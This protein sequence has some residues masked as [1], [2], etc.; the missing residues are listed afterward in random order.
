MRHEE[1]LLS[2]DESR[3]LVRAV[4]AYLDRTG[5]NYNRLV[6]A[7]AVN[8]SIRSDVTT[9]DKRLTIHTADK[10]RSAMKQN[11]TGIPKEQHKR[12][13]IRRTKERINRVKQKTRE[14]YPAQPVRVDRTPC[15]KC[16]V[17]KDI[18]CEHFPKGANDD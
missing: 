14:G 4:N 13:I 15:F 12:T 5:T 7:A 8:P 3:Q 2:H 11:P 10:I 16:G 17:R 1:F 18:G 9:R 6:T